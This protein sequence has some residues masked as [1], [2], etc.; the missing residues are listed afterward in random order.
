M[1]CVVKSHGL[2]GRRV[3]DP[4]GMIRNAVVIASVRPDLQRS[5]E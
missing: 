1:F 4:V 5:N 2:N 3:A